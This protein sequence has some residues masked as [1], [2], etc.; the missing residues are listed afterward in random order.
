MLFYKYTISFHGIKAKK[1][2]SPGAMQ[3][4]TAISFFRFPIVAE[5]KVWYSKYV[6]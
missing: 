4:F 3:E 6:W 5:E 2:V 1:R